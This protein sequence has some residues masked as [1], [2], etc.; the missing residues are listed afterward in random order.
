MQFPSGSKCCLSPD[1]GGNQWAEWGRED[2]VVSP[3]PRV[4]AVSLDTIAD[5]QFLSVIFMKEPHFYIL[6][7]WLPKFSSIQFSRSVVSDSL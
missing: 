4:P 2:L 7:P 1:D 3:L 5:L 6:S